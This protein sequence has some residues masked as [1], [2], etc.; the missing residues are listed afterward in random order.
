MDANKTW[1]EIVEILNQ[2]ACLRHES[3]W[4]A[5]EKSESLRA[6]I[7]RDGYLPD[8]FIVIGLNRRGALRLLE[9]LN[10]ELSAY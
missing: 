9:S 8:A 4:A 2:T 1:A 7:V 6:W 10:T 3:A 5:L